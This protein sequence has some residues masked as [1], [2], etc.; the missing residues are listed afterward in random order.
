MPASWVAASVR[1][2]LLGNRRL[3]TAGA[4]G[5]ARADGLGAALELLRRSPYGPNIEPGMSLEVAQRQV[6]A[7]ALWHVRLLAGWL[8]PGGSSVLQPLAAWFE[9]ANIEERLGYLSGGDHPPPY[10]L[11]RMGTAWR[12]VSAVT[13]PDAIRDALAQSRW[14]DPGTSDPGAMV[15][16]LRFRWVAW[17]SGAVPGAAVWAES[18]AALLAA[19]LCFTLPRGSLAPF[20]VAVFGLPAGWE[21]AGSA[22]DLAAMLPHRLAWV[23]DRVQEPSDLWMA[24]ARWWARVRRDA[25]DMVLRSR[26]ESSVVVGVAALLAHDAWLVRAAL[27]AAVRGRP[28]QG[29]FD[30]VA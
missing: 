25:I 20:A 8:P 3:G 7:T 26:F 13:T 29:V 16:A 12:A 14:G 23:L 4:A 22:H 27:S 6:A 10:Q 24:E 9:I 5:L 30:A 21:H 28:A 1:A 15:L 11:G 18:A 2:R 17:I 19:R